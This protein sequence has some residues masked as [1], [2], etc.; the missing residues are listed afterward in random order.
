VNVVVAGVMSMISVSSE[1][2]LQLPQTNSVG[3]ATRTCVPS[4]PVPG[5]VA[6]NPIGWRNSSQ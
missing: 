4:A 6:S 1:L 3:L 5:T 2:A